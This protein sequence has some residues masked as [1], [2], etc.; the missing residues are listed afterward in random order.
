MAVH[1]ESV[2]LQLLAT[3]SDAS[4]LRFQHLRRLLFAAD[5]ITGLISGV[6]IGAVASA[7]VPQTLLLA[8]VSPSR[9]RSPHSSAG[10]TRERTCGRGPAA[11]A[12]RRGSC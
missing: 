8:A 7:S 5:V 3:G 1:A 9:G 10:C 2:E 6:L 11:S 4:R 12:R